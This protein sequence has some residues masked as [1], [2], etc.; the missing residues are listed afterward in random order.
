MLAPMLLHLYSEEVRSKFCC[1]IIQLI[2]YRMSVALQH[3]ATCRQPER[4]MQLCKHKHHS[5]WMVC[6]QDKKNVVGKRWLR[7]EC[8]LNLGSTLSHTVYMTENTHSFLI[9]FFFF[10]ALTTS[11]FGFP[12]A[13]PAAGTHS[14]KVAMWSCVHANVFHRFTAFA[15]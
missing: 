15:L 3:T 9:L 8:C 4:P 7:Y 6:S 5:H 2:A 1:L 13:E 11:K 10:L 12:S 14:V